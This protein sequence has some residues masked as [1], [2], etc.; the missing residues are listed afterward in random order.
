VAAFFA[1]YHVPGIAHPDLIPLQ[2]LCVILSVG[3]SSRFFER[4]EKPGKA[5]EAQAEVGYPPSSPW[6]PAFCSSAVASPSISVDTLEKEIWEET[7]KLREQPLPEEEVRKAKKQARSYFLQGL[8]TLFSKG[9]LAGLYQVRAGDFRL[10]YP[11]LDRYES[12]TPDDVFR[13][14]R[15]YLRPENRTVVTLQPVSQK[16]HEDLGEVE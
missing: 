11:L 3:R 9:L 15:Q 7:E 8:Q 4:F 5:V 2:I 14:A 6:T 10:I 12:V 1:A 16:E 13:V